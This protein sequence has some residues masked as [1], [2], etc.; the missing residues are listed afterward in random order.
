MKVTW[1]GF[2]CYSNELTDDRF[3][4][5][6]EADYLNGSFRGTFTEDEFTSLTGCGGSVSGFIEHRHISF[7]KKYPFG[8]D[9]QADGLILIDEHQ[10]GHEVVYDGYFDEEKGVWEG[11]WEIVVEEIEINEAEYELIVDTG[12]WQMKRITGL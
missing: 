6:I 7:V 5:E 2:Y 9:E 11:S 10:E 4:F 1:K 12:Y 8:Y 3:G